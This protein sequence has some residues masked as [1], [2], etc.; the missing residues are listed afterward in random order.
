MSYL[1]IHSPIGDLTLFEEDGKLVSIDWG[2]VDGGAETP[3]L[4]EARSQLEHYFDGQR[5]DFDLPLAP[6]GT[7]FQRRVWDAL[8]RI[9]YGQALRY[10]DLAAELGSGP[11]AIGGACGRNPLPVV[12]PCHRV[13]AADGSLGGYSGVDGIDTKRALLDL[14]GFKGV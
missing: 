9:P 13:V 14:E 7:A 3:L 8:Q 11:R 6:A 10:G 2:W 12:I 1:S 5:Q 4:A